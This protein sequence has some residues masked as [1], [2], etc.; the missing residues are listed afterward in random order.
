[1]PTYRFQLHSLF[2]SL[3]DLVSDREPWVR[4]NSQAL[5]GRLAGDPKRRSKSGWKKWWEEDG[6]ELFLEAARNPPDLK[7]PPREEGRHAQRL[8]TRARKVTRYFSRL[9]NQG[10]DI[11]FV[12]DVTL[13]MTAQSGNTNQQQLA[14]EANVYRRSAYNRLIFSYLGNIGEAR[15]RFLLFIG[16]LGVLVE[17]QEQSAELLLVV[18]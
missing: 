17:V 1:M 9:R 7:L 13:S 5:L 2:K 16:E 15:R 12:I 18:G 10:L 14:L 8:T 3:V 4:L 11:L 6:R